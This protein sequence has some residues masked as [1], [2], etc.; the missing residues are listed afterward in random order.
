MDATKS[1]AEGMLELY[2]AVVLETVISFERELPM[3]VGCLAGTPEWE[4]ALN[5]GGAS[6]SGASLKS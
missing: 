3:P 1:D 5:S 6:L 2:A 4:F